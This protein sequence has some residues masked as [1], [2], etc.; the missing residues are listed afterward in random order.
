ML[1]LVSRGREIDLLMQGETVTC[2]HCVPPAQ[3]GRAGIV[4][5]GD[6]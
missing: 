2:C 3:S 6:W 5:R 1:N 4:Q